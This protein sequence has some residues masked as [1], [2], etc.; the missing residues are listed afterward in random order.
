MT[1]SR[2]GARQARVA[3]HGSTREQPLRQRDAD[4]V[5]TI[6]DRASATGMAL[7]V[8]RENSPYDTDESGEGNEI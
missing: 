8:T 3:V 4:G 6:M 7:S 1:W 5:N 2:R